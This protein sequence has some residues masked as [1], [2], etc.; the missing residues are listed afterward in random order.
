MGSRS[1]HVLVQVRFRYSSL[2]AL[3]YKLGRESPYV[4][5]IRGDREYVTSHTG[6]LSTGP[7][8]TVGMNEESD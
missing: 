1:G 8:E 7:P 3:R 6:P 2:G 4:R 5:N